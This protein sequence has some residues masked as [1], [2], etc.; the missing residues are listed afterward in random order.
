[1]I[2]EA[3]EQ[4]TFEKGNVEEKAAWI[5]GAVY[6]ASHARIRDRKKGK[7]GKRLPTILDVIFK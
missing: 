2:H 3:T 1:L 4:G 7:Q 6:M 5:L